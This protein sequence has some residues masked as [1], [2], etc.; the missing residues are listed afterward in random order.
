ME[1][2]TIELPAGVAL[3]EKPASVNLTCSVAEYHLNYDYSH[4]GKI[5]VTREMKAT[6]D[7]LNPADYNAFKDF[8]NKVAEADTKQIAFK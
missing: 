2:L 8:F 7:I 6:A 1:Q 3:Q 4:A 5:V